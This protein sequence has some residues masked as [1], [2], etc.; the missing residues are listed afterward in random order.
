MHPEIEAI[1]P[2]SPLQQGLLF[3]QLLD[4][5]GPD[6]YLVQTVF[7]LT[8]PLDDARLRHAA[9]A[10]LQRHPQLRSSFVQA[11][12]K[13]PVQIIPK[14]TEPSWQQIEL[15]GEHPDASWDAILHEDRIRG[16]RADKGPLLRWTL[17]RVG[18]EHHRL[19][20]THHHLL[21]DGWSIPI[22]LHE[23]FALYRG[24]ALAAPT[25]YQN[26][27][28]WLKRQNRESAKA[29]W[30][31]HL[32]G[33]DA[34]TMLA[35][36]ISTRLACAPRTLDVH[37]GRDRADALRQR[38]RTLG[39]TLNT[40]FQT[41]WAIWLGRH[42]GRSDVIFGIT[43]SGRSPEISGVE[44]MVGL[45]INTL[46]LR[47]QL[48][49]AQSLGELAVHIQDEQVALL[50]HQHLG[51]ADIQQAAGID[52]LFDTHFVFE[53]LP[54][55]TSHTLGDPAQSLHCNDLGGQGGDVTHY[56]L[57]LMALPNENIELR[58]GYRPDVFGESDVQQF[59][60]RFV[61]IL[62][63]IAHTPHQSTRSVALLDE[64]ELAHWLAQAQPQP[65]AWP[66]AYL[67]D[68]FAEQA[69]RTPDAL[70]IVAGDDSLTYAALA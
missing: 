27:F 20:V 18:D 10:L 35:P 11:G 42:T 44:Q 43:V 29:A 45:F 41:A 51:L 16:F 63:A 12:F 7:Q 46:P 47:V 22:V 39:V 1:L 23:L 64:S 21:L 25:P 28:T 6:A 32:S 24:D 4:E 13:E 56:P 54:G 34:P 55:E 33:I 30:R 69:A 37:L 31:E 68:L 60:R 14:R 48:D 40:L 2:L 52:A 65:Q 19:L 61:R 9:G 50:D 5:G 66:A 15:P 3:H 8:G 59:A 62:D 38:A 70:A 53:N 57:G 17:A 26:Y 36:S 58:F 49:A 67:P